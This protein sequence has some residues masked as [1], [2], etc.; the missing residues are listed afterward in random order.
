MRKIILVLAV[1]L[2]ISLTANAQHKGKEHKN[3][4][5]KELNLDAEQKVKLNKIYSQFREKSQNLRNDSLLSNKEK[6]DK[7]HEL[8]RERKIAINDILT[9]EQQDKAKEFK[10]EKLAEKKNHKHGKGRKH[11][12]MDAETA[13]QFKELKDKFHKQ[14]KAIEMTRIAPD[15]KERRIQELKSNFRK[16]REKLFSS[17][18]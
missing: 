10:K 12:N 16:D 6:R 18:I 4:Y 15:E 3:N 17:N 13:S 7:K 5:L 11:H 2:T 9:P 8:F 14:K 1:S